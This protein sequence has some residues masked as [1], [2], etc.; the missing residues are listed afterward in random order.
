MPKNILDYLPPEYVPP[1]IAAARDPASPEAMRARRGPDLRLLP[2]AL[3]TWAAVAV[4]I[5]LRDATAVIACLV[6]L[7]LTA[8]GSIIHPAWAGRAIRCAQVTRA[9][10]PAIAVAGIA[11]VLAWLKILRVDTS[12]LRT[13]QSFNGTA[14]IAEIPRPL[15]SGGLMLPVE[16]PIG[17]VPLFLSPEHT[18]KADLSSLHPG[19]TLRLGASLRESD[20]PGIVP[21]LARATEP[22]TVEQSPQGLW[23]VTAYLRQ[24]FRE[25]TAPLPGDTGQLIPGLVLGDTTSQSPQLRQDFLHTGLSHLTAVSGA[26]CAMLASAVMILAAWCG[27]SQRRQ[28][29]WAIVALAGFVCLVGP[30]PSVLRAAMMGLVGLIAVASSRWGDVFAALNAAIIV[31]L[32]FAPS[33][34]LSYGFALSVAATLGIVSAAPWLSR[35]VLEKLWIAR[36]RPPRRWQVI[37]VRSLI[38]AVVADISTV[39]LIVH[40]TGQAP[41]VTVLANLLVAPAVPL[42]TLLGLCAVPVA[43]CAAPLGTVCVSLAALPAAWIMLVARTLSDAPQLAI[44]G[45]TLA[46]GGLLAILALC[47]VSIAFPHRMIQLRWAWLLTAVM[48]TLAA[49]SG[50]MAITS[51]ARDGTGADGTRTTGKSV[52]SETWDD[53]QLAGRMIVDVATERDALAVTDLP[54]DSTVLRITECPAG[55]NSAK[56]KQDARPALTPHGIP[57]VYD[58]G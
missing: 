4:T 10:R 26:N 35:L 31:L 49:R 38:V 24:S 42:V 7:L 33:L 56:L 6:L 51:P 1:A 21:L 30:E 29:L 58:C 9:A 17:Q 55:F 41:L 14:R 37:A 50:V 15:D 53:E 45:G 19:A 34:A 39:P 8:A 23:A 36:A 13:M 18:A 5:T 40:M 25:A 52:T 20:R 46:L 16:L 28:P 2:V 3:A 22:V 32:F 44:Q 11:A 12:P 48:L 57:V 54:T 47:L 43:A 27:I